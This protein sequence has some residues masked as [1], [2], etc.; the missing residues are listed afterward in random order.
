MTLLRM[1]AFQPREGAAGAAG[2]APPRQAATG[3][4]A[5]VPSPPPATGSRQ[6]LAAERPS[7]KSPA[8]ASDW[9]DPDWAGLI[10]DL[11]LTGASKLLASNCV[12]LRRDKNVIQLGLDRRSESLLTRSRQQALAEALSARFG[13]TLKVDITVGNEAGGETPLQA[14]ARQVDEKLEAARASLES[15]PNVKALR[16]MFGAEMKPDSI[17]LIDRRRSAGQE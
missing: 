17:E 2:S 6:S 14:E 8:G 7:G 12:Y 1:L 5:R 9:Q 11:G 4:A 16:D 10:A 15:D 3:R 13:E